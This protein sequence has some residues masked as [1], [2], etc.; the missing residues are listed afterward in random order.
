MK[1]EALDLAKEARKGN[2]NYRGDS[3]KFRGG[4]R[5]MI[6]HLNELI[7]AVES[8]IAFVSDYIGNLSSGKKVPVVV[9]K[10]SRTNEVIDQFT[11]Q[12]VDIFEMT[13]RVILGEW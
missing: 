5:D 6:D 13:I 9:S 3:T 8:P 10:G 7:D 2:L 11:G 12:G 4:W 1:E